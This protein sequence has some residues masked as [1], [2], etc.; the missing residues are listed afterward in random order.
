MSKEE[1][2]PID[3]QQ[4]LPTFIEESQEMLEEADQLLLHM[5]VH[6]LKIED[7]NRIFRIMHS[8]K[9]NSAVFNFRVMNE[10]TH[11]L[12][13]FLNEMRSHPATIKEND[14]DVIFKSVDCLRE[15]V[16]DIAKKKPM[17]ETKAHELEKIIENKIHH[18]E[19]QPIEEKKPE[20]EVPKNI[21]G[22][23]IRFHPDNNTFQTGSDPLR[24][25]NA[26]KEFGQLE[27]SVDTQ[28]LPAF[29]DLNPEVC[30]L[31]WHMKLHG[32]VSLQQIEETCSWVTSPENLQI[33]PLPQEKI[34]ADA[35]TKE[36]E[37]A[38]SMSVRVSTDKIDALINMIGE[39]VITQS[40]LGQIVKDCKIDSYENI[41]EALIQL[42]ENSRELQAGIMRIR[43]IPIEFLFHRYQRMAHDLAKQMGKKIKLVMAG[44]QTELDKN[45]I[46]KL[47]NPLLHLIRNSIDHGIE[48]PEVRKNKE[49]SEIGTI[50][51]KAYQDGGYI[52]IKV[53]DDGAGLNKEEILQKGISLGLVNN[54]ALLSDEQ[55][56]SLIFKPGFSTADTVSE[57]SGRGVGLDVVAKN[58]QEIKGEIR[59]E[60]IPGQGT[61]FILR[62]PL[63]LAI[64][65]CQLVTVK[66][67]TYII[68]LANITEMLS[69]DISQVN[70]ADA[71]S[72]LY[73]FRDEYIPLINVQKTLY[74]GIAEDHFENKFLIIVDVD[75]Q[76]VGLVV[77]ELLAQ[78]RV[79]IKS[80]EENYKKIQGISGV[81][82]LGNGQIALIIDV[83]AI[84]NFT[85]NPDKIGE[86]VN[87]N[88]KSSVNK[89]EKTST[90]GD[91]DAFQFLT[92]L[93]SGK[94]YG[95]DLSLVRE[96]RM[97]EDVTILPNSPAYL[98]GAINVRGVI[99][100]II[101]LA[102]CFS[103]EQFES[104]MQ[105]VIITLNI[106]Q[107]DQDRCVG[108]IVEQVLDT[109][110]INYKD[111]LPLPSKTNP[112]L[113]NYVDGLVSV[114]GKMIM[115]LKTNNLLEIV[116]EGVEV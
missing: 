61:T 19:D 60:T 3:V 63:T 57:I 56:Y 16:G 43:M 79:V 98:K 116:T 71:G 49:K 23:D 113:K 102:E 52:I 65:D 103:L 9:G 38:P 29:S 80:L 15:M 54:A 21:V 12:E 37:L 7:I 24:L 39:L 99:V 14:I 73:Y 88:E 64:M 45:M 77:D 20:E 4:F 27:L 114:E 47:A 70:E 41:N 105:N 107:N 109:H 115:L 34:S 96:I 48:L 11:T 92:F 44:E 74:H 101:D 26:L 55:I 90:H 72:Y 10:L 94:E 17:N 33:K 75:H 25:F 6:A 95:I 32:N 22:W 110:T 86:K 69:V 58:I 93:M 28:K 83:T 106:D 62:I 46:E 89:Q 8:I 30:Y 36:V 2:M 112:V 5:D 31:S 84:V 82:I 50:Q 35:S 78:Q 87:L 42:E 111:I 66:N 76:L 51:L 104:H 81:T 40:M 91:L 67:Q 85:L 59:I 97:L 18:M 13:T 100:P 1:A 53:M 68:P 108:T